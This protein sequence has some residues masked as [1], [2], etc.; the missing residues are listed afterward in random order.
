MYLTGRI[1][2]IYERLGPTLRELG[3]RMRLTGPE[4]DH[5]LFFERTDEDGIA[6]RSPVNFVFLTQ[7]YTKMKEPT[8]DSGT[9]FLGAGESSIEPIGTN[10]WIIVWGGYTEHCMSVGEDEA[11]ET[12]EEAFKDAERRLRDCPLVP[13]E[14]CLPG[15]LDDDMVATLWPVIQEICNAHGIEEINVGREASKCEYYEFEY[16][17]VSFRLLFDMDQ[18]IHVFVDDRKKKRLDANCQDSVEKAI[19]ALLKKLDNMGRHGRSPL[20]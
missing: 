13:E 18:M 20:S 14:T 6:W 19:G 7:E 15:I 1:R 10:G 8:W 17:D 9:I 11:F 4:S 16:L 5:F 2:D 12:W 3:L